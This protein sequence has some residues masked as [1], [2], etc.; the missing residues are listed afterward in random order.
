MTRVF[1]LTSKF[2]VIDWITTKTCFLLYI[3]C[4]SL[5][6]KYLSNLIVSLILSTNTII[7]GIRPTRPFLGSRKAKSQKRDF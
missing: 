4:G 6:Y 5:D 7:F 2:D 3:Q 1:I